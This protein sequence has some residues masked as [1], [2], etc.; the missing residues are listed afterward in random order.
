MTYDE[1]L[2]SWV[3]GKPIHG[4]P[5]PLEQCV[6]D[7]SCC[8][9]R[10]LAPEAVREVFYKALAAGN[11]KVITRM[12]MEFVGKAFLLAPNS[13]SNVYIAGLDASREE[14]LP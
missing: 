2:V 13:N 12:L 3:E 7:F 5:G 10:L 9:P 6:P 11:E 14:R 1:Q 8:E 4:E